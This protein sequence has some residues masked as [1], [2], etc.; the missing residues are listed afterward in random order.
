MKS[1]FV[2]SIASAVAASDYP[3]AQHLLFMDVRGEQDGLELPVTTGSFPA[4]LDGA[5]YNNGFGQFEMGQGAHINHLADGMSHL[6]K[7]KISNGTVRLWNKVQRTKYWQESWHRIPR[8]RTFNGTTPGFEALDWLLAETHEVPPTPDNLNVGMMQL[9]TSSERIWANSDMPGFNE[10]DEHLNYLGP[11]HFREDK[12]YVKHAVATTFTAT[13][14]GN[15]LGDPYIYGFEVGLRPGK[16]PVQMGVWRVNMDQHDAGP[17]TSLD[18][19]WLAHTT[20]PSMENINYQH[21]LANTPNYLVFVLTPFQIN[22]ARM[23]P[24]SRILKSMHYS[25]ERDSWSNTLLVFDKRTSKFVKTFTSNDFWFYHYVNCYEDG[26][27]IVMDLNS[28]DYRHIM[29]AFS[30]EKLR[31]DVPKEF[32]VKPTLRLTLDMAAADGS[33][34][35]TEEIG[36]SYDLGCIHP[37]LHGYKYRWSWGI[38]WTGDH[39]WWDSIIKHDVVNRK[40]TKTFH[41]PEHYPGELNA[42]AKPW[43]MEEDDVVILTVMLDG[44]A[45]T[46]YLM[47]LDGKDLSTIAAAKAPYPLP[48]GSHGCWQPT[49]GKQGCIGETQADPHGKP[50]TF[51]PSG[52]FCCLYPE[53]L[54]RSDCGSCGEKHYDIALEDC[55][56]ENT[57]CPIWEEL[58]G[59]QAVV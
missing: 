16:N 54:D 50:A 44:L 39:L 36:P 49:G 40:V 30:I 8:F 29:T 55:N 41:M 9:T 2:S 34:F 1:V 48:F 53:Y 13:H 22:L 56:N 51:P 28:Q 47:A 57:W 11:M 6:T 42:V 24:H 45:G 25:A 37:N 59:K 46:S 23:L 15:V 26:N 27:D 32:D 10:A 17:G 43:A 31:Y 38:A 52:G 18:R 58:E 19:E 21:A 33:H 7:W 14:I 4:W 5:K 35:T 12:N 3:N 20:M